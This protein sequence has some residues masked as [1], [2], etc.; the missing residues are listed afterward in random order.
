MPSGLD[1]TTLLIT[2]PH[3]P[4]ALIKLI[5]P[6]AKEDVNISWIESRPYQHRNWNYLFFLDIDGHQ[7]DAKVKQALGQLTQQPVMVN[8]LG[9]YPKAL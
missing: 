2:T 8:I 3:T 9:S 1:K 5:Q 7:E 4:G 6:F